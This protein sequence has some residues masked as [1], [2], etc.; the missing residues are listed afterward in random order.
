MPVYRAKAASAVALGHRLRGNPYEFTIGESMTVGHGS[1]GFQRHLLRV[2]A[3]T[4]SRPSGRRCLR[5][6]QDMNSSGIRALTNDTRPSPRVQEQENC[7]PALMEPSRRHRRTS[8]E[9][10]SPQVARPPP[11]VA[12]RVST[13]GVDK[14]Q[15]ETCLNFGTRIAQEIDIPIFTAPKHAFILAHSHRLRRASGDVSRW[16]RQLALRVTG[17][18]DRSTDTK[19]VARA[20]IVAAPS[21]KPSAIYQNV[22]FRLAHLNPNWS[23]ASTTALAMTSHA[24]RARRT[25][26]RSLHAH[27]CFPSLIGR[28]FFQN[29]C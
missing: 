23:Q 15:M 12:A 2:R 7:C 1:S 6:R 28:K 26:G 27:P 4:S 13:R 20:K 11:G 17:G 22:N 25:Y 14:N 24:L 19:P 5:S 3:P 18:G 10:Q 21:G 8:I 16:M 29:T 9:T